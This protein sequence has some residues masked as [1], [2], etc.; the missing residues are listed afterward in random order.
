[1]VLG[2]GPTEIGNQWA[3]VIPLWTTGGRLLG[4]LAVGA[5]GW[6]SV[7][8]SVLE[9]ALEP[10][11]ALAFKVG[12][13]MENAAMAERLL[14]AEKLSGLGLLAG[15]M[16]HALNNPLT[17]VLG[18][19]ELIA[20]TTREGRVKEDAEVIV[21]EA[22]RMRETVEALLEF[23]QPMAEGVEPVDVTLL[24]RGLAEACAGKL[25]GR[26]VRL[27]VEA[28][29]E[30]TVV[31]GNRVRLRQMMEHLLNNAAQALA[32]A[33]KDEEPM[34]RVSVSAAGERVY[35]LVSDTGP[36]FA[37]P[38]RAFEP[39]GSMGLGLSVCYGIVHEHGGE[40]SAFN[41][42]PHGAG[43]AVEF[44]LVDFAMKTF[45][46]GATDRIYSASV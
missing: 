25:A 32:A 8:R 4:A 30:V 14:R 1:M 20:D 29:D 39:C 5:D 13:A 26:G 22:L 46:R 37:E 9:K 10:L 3:I 42:H 36:G 28:G 7:R 33:K 43:V 31:R 18:F 16:A 44:P 6:M 27:V 12:R 40:I 35:L 2:E 21:R 11:E 45:E 41:L 23:W 15:G 34:I 24:I 38:G 17:A 19:A